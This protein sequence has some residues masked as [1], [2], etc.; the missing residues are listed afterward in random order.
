LNE[1]AGN[2]QDSPNQVIHNVVTQYLLL[3]FLYRNVLRVGWHKESRQKEAQKAA[4]SECL[5]S[6]GCGNADFLSREPL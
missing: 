1:K 5:N 4:D 3:K 6:N 2:M